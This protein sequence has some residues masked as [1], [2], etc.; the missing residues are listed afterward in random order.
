MRIVVPGSFG[1]NATT[2]A[3]MRGGICTTACAMMFSVDP[4]GSFFYCGYIAFAM[5]EKGANMWSS[6]K[7][8]QFFETALWI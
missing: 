2:F 6:R 4:G 8:R 3:P 1:K 7:V 5:T